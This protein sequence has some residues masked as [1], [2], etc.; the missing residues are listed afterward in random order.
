MA[1]FFGAL[2]FKMKS[3]GGNGE[4]RQANYRVMHVMA[5]L[6]VEKRIIRCK[7]S[8]WWNELSNLQDIVDTILTMSHNQLTAKAG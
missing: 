5:A 7:S 2:A 1:Q 8:F 4:V 3:T 6:G